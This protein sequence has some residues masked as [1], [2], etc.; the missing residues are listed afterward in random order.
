ML[1]CI[2]VRTYVYVGTSILLYAYICDVY[3][4][5]YI[6][7]NI[8]TK[9]I[10]INVCVCCESTTAPIDYASISDCASIVLL[11][12]HPF[13]VTFHLLSEHNDCVF[14]ASIL[15]LIAHLVFFLLRP[16]IR[17]FLNTLILFFLCL[18]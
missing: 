13:I 15:F 14:S 1:V 3:I 5:I 8:Y 4:Y 9:V 18:S 17:F 6:H 12:L 11:F 16:F 7:I 10:D 2:H